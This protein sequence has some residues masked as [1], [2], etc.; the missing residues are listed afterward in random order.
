MLVSRKFQLEKV[1]LRVFAG[2]S[3]IQLLHNFAAF[4]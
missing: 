4:Y 3:T 1:K 2:W